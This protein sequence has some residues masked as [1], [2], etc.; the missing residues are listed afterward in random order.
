MAA[1]E[2]LPFVE[3][4]AQVDGG[5]AVRLDDPAEHNPVLVRTLVQAGADVQFVEEVSHSLES[6]YF[7]LMAQTREEGVA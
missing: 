5:L 6:V 4:V 2:R 1:I 7:D 3:R